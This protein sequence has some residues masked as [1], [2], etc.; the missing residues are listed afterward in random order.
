M[1]SSCGQELRLYR[2]A[3]LKAS[4]PAVAQLQPFGCWMLG[5]ALMGTSPSLEDALN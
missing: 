2:A 3:R 5:A 4:A 1:F